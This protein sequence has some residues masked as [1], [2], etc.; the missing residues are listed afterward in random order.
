MIDGD[1]VALRDGRTLRIIGVNAAEIS[2][3]DVRV[4]ALAI[5][6]RDR[7]RV[8]LARE[9]NSV[10]LRFDE[11]RR[12]KYGRLLA[13]AFVSDGTSVAV[14]LQDQ[15]LATAL[16]VPPNVWNQRC[17]GAAEADARAR[18][19]GL[20]H[21]PEYQVV[22]A[23]TVR[24]G[25]RGYRWVRGRVEHL[26]RSDRTIWLDLPGR[27]A[28]RID[29]EDLRYF[30]SITLDQLEG[31]TV[32]ARGWMYPVGSAVHLRIRH[33]AALEVLDR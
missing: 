9:G 25:T 30:G 28:L 12:D 22:E 26:G 5:S 19:L 1:T 24:A 13:H 15:G 17:Y 2:S 11:Q 3:D 8:W 10:N 31:K 29:H 32:I 14:W 33:P 7:L 16:T 21:L 18:G 20:W 23:A 4:R 6:A 27:V